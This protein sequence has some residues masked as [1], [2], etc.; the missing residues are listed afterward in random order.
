MARVSTTKN[1]DGTIT[2]THGRTTVNMDSIR[3]VGTQYEIMDTL[4]W[5]FLGRG[6][7]LHENELERIARDVMG[8]ME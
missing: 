8:V 3:L 1:A 7:T 4:T 5:E 6:I 2:I